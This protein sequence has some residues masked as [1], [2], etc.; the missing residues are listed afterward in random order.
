MDGK[1]NHLNELDSTTVE[2]HY[3]K[4]N[5]K[6]KAGEAE[7][8]AQYFKIELS[9]LDYKAIITWFSKGNIQ[10]L[11][12]NFIYIADI[13]FTRDYTGSFSTYVIIEHLLD[14]GFR[15]EKSNDYAEKTIIDNNNTVGN[16]CLSF[17]FNNVRFKIYN[18][19][20]HTIEVKK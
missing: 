5:L 13:D 16:N 18:K 19:L 17:L 2:A 12:D 8:I 3:K 4:Y 14:L 20:W 11:N 7:A 9:N 10:R 6:Y 1:G 15:M